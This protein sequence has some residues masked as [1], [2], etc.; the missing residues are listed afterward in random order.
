MLKYERGRSTEYVA[1]FDGIDVSLLAWKDNKIVNLIS[2]YV[3]ER[4]FE[5]INPANDTVSAPLTQNKPT[6]SRFCKRTNTRIEIACPNIIKEYNKHMGGVDLLD[7]CMGRNR[8]STKSRK[9]TSRVFYHLLDITM[10]NAWVFYKRVNRIRQDPC[11]I[12]S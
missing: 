9:W 7:S 5:I 6:T 12:I 10:V 11:L 1:S 8:I 3:G 2:T 4:P